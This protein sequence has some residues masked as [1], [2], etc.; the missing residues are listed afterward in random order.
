MKNVAKVFIIIGMV[1]GWWMIAPLIIGAI[2]LNKLKNAKC[3]DD[4]GVAICV[5]VLIL[6]STPA[7]IMMLCM[8]DE[9]FCGEGCGMPSDEIPDIPDIPAVPDIPTEAP[10]EEAG[11][12]N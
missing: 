1:A 5:V 10:A 9:H 12:S 4:L 6:C 7:G 8:N 3:K 2:A 11:S